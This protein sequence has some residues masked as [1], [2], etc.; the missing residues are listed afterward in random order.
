MKHSPSFG[1]PANT[2]SRGSESTSPCPTSQK[3]KESVH[4]VESSGSSEEEE[5]RRGLHI[6]WSEVD[7]IR[8]MSSW[9]KH[10]VHPIQ[11][12]N[13]KTEHYWKVVADEFNANM[14]SNE[15]KRTP[16]QCRVHWGNVK[17]DVTKLCGCY[18]RAISTFTSGYSDDMT[19]QGKIFHLR[20]FVERSQRPAQ[21]EENP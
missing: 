10:S 19:K 6:N 11:G 1:I 8:L 21:M 12:N 20:V 13:K 15:H 4:V 5:G 16:K 7:N 2:S 14:P 3:Q 18:S 9:L 17:R